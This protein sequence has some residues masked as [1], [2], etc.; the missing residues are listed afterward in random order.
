[1]LVSQKRSKSLSYTFRF[2]KLN[3]TSPIEVARGGLT[4]VCVSHRP[5]GNMAAVSIPDAIAEL[6]QVAPAELLA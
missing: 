4:V 1:M 6:I 2:K 3:A 5:G